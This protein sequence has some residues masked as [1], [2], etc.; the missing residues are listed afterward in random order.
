MNWYFN[1]GKDGDIVISSRVRFARN[2]QGFNYTN[3]LN[4]TKLEEILNIFEN[5]KQLLKKYGLKLL[6]LENMDD[7]TKASLVEKHLI[8]IE[9]LKSKA[10]AILI[11]DEENICIMLNEEDHL[12]IQVFSAGFEIYNIYE[13]L[14]NID[15]EFGKCI[16]YQY[17]KNYGYLTSCPSNVGTGFRCSVMLH[18]PALQLSRKL[19]KIID[20]ANNLNINIR[21]AYGEGTNSSGHMYQISNKITIGVTEKEILDNINNI[22]SQLITLEREERNNLLK[23]KLQ[24]EDNINRKYGILSNAKIIS[25]QE[26]NEYISYIRMGIYMK[27][28]DKIDIKKLNKIGIYTK[29]ACLQKYFGKVLSPNERDVYRARVIKD[30]LEEK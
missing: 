13:I 2:I 10:S 14:N 18:L 9:L 24:L 19:N 20:I 12:R 17:N 15:D 22:V 29:V 23:N 5:N 3:N 8:S 1:E 28:I 25:S 21:G 30:I 4:K 11:N 16:T 27:L 26:I 6:R 7:I